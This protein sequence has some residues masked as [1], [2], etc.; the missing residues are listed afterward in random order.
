MES[1]ADRLA[2]SSTGVVASLGSAGAAP[3]PPAMPKTKSMSARVSDVFF[4]LL[5]A[6]AAAA[7]WLIARSSVI[8]ATS[9]SSS[10]LARVIDS[11]HML[12]RSNTTHTHTHTW[13]QWA[14]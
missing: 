13:A 3:V 8:L 2:V 14:A 11:S 12:H 6:A 5:A 10:G 4:V 7:A 9:R 1:V